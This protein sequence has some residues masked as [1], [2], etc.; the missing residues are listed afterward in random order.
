MRTDIVITLTVIL[1]YAFFALGFIYGFTL[2]ILIGIGIS[3]LSSVGG[4][5]VLTKETE[6]NFQS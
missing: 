4:I 3:F 6:D 2:I 1:L 5:I